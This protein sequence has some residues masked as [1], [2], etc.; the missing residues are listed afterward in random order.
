M[1]AYWLWTSQKLSSYFADFKQ[2][3]NLVVIFVGS[4]QVKSVKPSRRLTSLCQTKTP[5]G[6]TPWLTERHA[7]PMVTLFFGA[8]MLITGSHVMPVV[9]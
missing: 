1:V 9:I 4:E 8:I 6:E 3:K 2:A 5:F 7:T